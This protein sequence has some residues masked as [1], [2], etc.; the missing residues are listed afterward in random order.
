MVRY[1][2][3]IENCNFVKGKDVNVGL[4]GMSFLLRYKAIGVLKRDAKIRDLQQINNFESVTWR[5]TVCC[6]SVRLLSVRCK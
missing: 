5:L 2:G 4:F 3:E 6:L 1:G